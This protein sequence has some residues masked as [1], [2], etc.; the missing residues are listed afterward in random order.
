MTFPVLTVSGGTV[1][2]CG[3]GLPMA[4]DGA[5]TPARSAAECGQCPPRSPADWG[6]AV[7]RKL[8]RGSVA[9][10]AVGPQGTIFCL[11]EGGPNSDNTLN[12]R[13]LSIARFKLE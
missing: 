3:P 1:F 2:R 5:T 4:G 11:H 10:I 8:G 6:L 9:D 7:W 12:T 13:W